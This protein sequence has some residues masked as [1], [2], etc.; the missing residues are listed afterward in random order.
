VQGFQLGL[1]NAKRGT[2]EALG[3]RR[4]HFRNFYIDVI[5]PAAARGE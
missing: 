5:D 4:D 2:L 1:D 3:V